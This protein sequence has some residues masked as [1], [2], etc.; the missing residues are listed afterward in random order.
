L[1][2]RARQ[3]RTTF[4]WFFDDFDVEGAATAA[5]YQEVALVFIQADSGE[6]IASFDDN[7]GDRYVSSSVSPFP[8]PYKHAP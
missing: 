1:Q 2:A 5:A 3:D 6:E 8:D 4:S 7:Y